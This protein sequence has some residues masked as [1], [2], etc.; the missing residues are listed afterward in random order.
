MRKYLSVVLL[1]VWMPY[2]PARSEEQASSSVPG[3]V[4]GTFGMTWHPGGAD[5]QQGIPVA[6]GCFR[7]HHIETE[8]RVPE[9]LEGLSGASVEYGR[10]GFSDSVRTTFF[11]GLRKS[12]AELVGF[13]EFFIDLNRDGRIEEDEILKG[14]NRS[15]TM[16]PEVTDCY[17]GPVE[18]PLV[19]QDRPRVHRVFSWYHMLGAS[20]PGE[21]YLNSHC[22]LSGRIKLGDEELEA[23]LIDYNCDGRYSAGHTDLQW[24]GTLGRREQ[25]YDLIGWDAD[26]SGQIDRFEMEFI[27]GCTVFKG[28]AY[29]IDCSPDGR[30]VTVRALDVPMGHL[31]MPADRAYVKLVGELGPIKLL[32]F[33]GTMPLPAGTYW[34]D[35]ASIEEPNAE[36]G[37]VTTSKSGQYFEAPWEIRPDATRTIERREL[38]VT[39]QDR[40]RFQAR[41]RALR[42]PP[43]QSLLYQPLGNLEEFGLRLDR[44]ALDRK[45]VLLCF[46]DFQ[47]RPSRNCLLQLNELSDENAAIVAVQASRIERG[48]LDEWIEENG[49]RVRIGMIEADEKQTRV[50]WGIE[51]LPWLILTNEE[52][53]VTAEGFA[54][55]DLEDQ[56]AQ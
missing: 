52:H 28:K 37:F 23:V 16:G 15:S 50:K 6:P 35:Y 34:V 27:G 22:Y 54:V 56:L 43:R 20:N 9:G 55:A 18:L 42:E 30:T 53:I 5:K 21:L 29:R 8:P 40:Q 26:G 44:D 19:G 48:T 49:I 7:V 51:S 3:R 33:D 32:T 11:C 14:E 25:D 46:F 12:S 4:V 38:I 45:R 31:R 47:Q 36:G 24:I 1:L 10:A 2:S 39:A 41:L 17:Y 13:D